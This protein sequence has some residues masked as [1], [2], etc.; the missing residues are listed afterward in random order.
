METKIK[1]TAE[2]ILALRE[3]MDFTQEEMAA[4]SDVSLPDYRALESG[5]RDFSFT[6]LLKCAQKFGVDMVELLT[7]ENPKLSGYTIVRK[8][9]GLN[10]NRRAGFTYEHLATYFKG[11]MAEPFL[12]TAPYLPEEQGKEIHLSSHEGQEL[13]YVLSGSLRVQIGDHAETLNAGDTIYYDSSIG[14]GMVAVG[15]QPCD[16]LAIV[17]KKEAN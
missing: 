3:I 2:R 5:E 14:H 1:E 4:A 13:D 11:K 12:V 10:I 16:F 15:G 8:G 7:G 6:F 9:T 17:M